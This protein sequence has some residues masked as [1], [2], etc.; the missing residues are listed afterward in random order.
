M[1]LQSKGTFTT[2]NKL[3]LDFRIITEGLVLIISSLYF[4]QY[5]WI[6]RSADASFLILVTLIINTNLEHNQLYLTLATN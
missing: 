1:Y 5:L 4:L 2:S 6:C 3:M